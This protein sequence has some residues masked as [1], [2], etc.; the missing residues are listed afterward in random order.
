MAENYT[1]NDT[2]FSN[3][4]SKINLAVGVTGLLQLPVLLTVLLLMIFVYK[5]YRTTFQRLILYL[6][7][8]G[9]WF[10]FSF[11]LSSLLVSRHTE[12]KWCIMEHLFSF[13]S[14]IAYYTY[15]AA[16]TNSSLL[17]IPCLMRGR[18]VSKRTSRCVECIC[19]ALT[20]TLA[21][22]GSSEMTVLA[23]TG[24]AA[25]HTKTGL[26]LNQIQ[27]V[28][29]MSVYF[30]VDL[31]V[32][33]VSLSLCFAFCFIRQRIRIRQIAVLLRNSVCHVA[34][35]AIVMGVDA[36]GT[37]Y[38]IYIRTTQKF[39]DS[40]SFLDTTAVLMLDVLFVLA[41]GVSV[42]VQALLCIKTSTQGNICCK[43]C[44]CE[45]QNQ[46]QHLYAV[47]DGEDTATNPASSRVS[48]PSYTN[49]AV[50]YTG[51]FTQVNAS[52]NNDGEDE[53]RSL[54]E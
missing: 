48:Q 15:I 25:N 2:E 43:R 32:V 53:Q 16:I 35:N 14:E 21:L 20:I 7:I 17:L 10:Q 47:I 34:I 6:V 18:P 8:I 36:V 45:N 26:Q 37:G 23:K 4:F 30:V 13:S 50:P 42:I 39:F 27:G 40:R 46:I 33:L 1:I 52:I 31:E 51:G 19:V 41:V 3:I 5:T 24:C 22:A 49:F 38:V 11:G 29:I 9:L 28:I 12:E 44:C 54:I